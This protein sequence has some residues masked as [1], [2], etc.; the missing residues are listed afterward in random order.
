[1]RT[2]LLLGGMLTVGLLVYLAFVF[3]REDSSLSPEQTEFAVAD[4]SEVARIVLSQYRGEAMTQ[5]VR[6]HRG[7]EGW[8]VNEQSPALR[9][10]VQHL[11]RVM[12]RL[13]VRE[14]LNEAGERTANRFFEATRT[15]VEIMDADG[16]YLKHYFI[17]S[18]T[19]DARGT[20]MRM[21]DTETPY[22]VEMPGLQGY[23]KASFTLDPML[24]R[25]NRLFLADTS[26]LQQLR[27]E[28]TGQPAQS[29]TLQR[30]EQGRWRLAKAKARPHRLTALLSRF[31]GMVYAESF[32]NAD[33][34]GRQQQ[35]AEHAPDLRLRATYRDGRQRAVVLY[36]RS[37]NPNNLFAWVEGVE[38]L[39]TVQ[40]FVIDPFLPGRSYL[41]GESDV[42]RTPLDA[43]A[44]A[45]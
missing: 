5:Q 28:F 7:S 29:W 17:G 31:Q 38:E 13:A 16:Q 36:D 23:V 2:T 37:D 20:L 21:A 1:M 22:V 25:A 43:K 6:L 24:W 9:P 32:A 3:G 19:P 44:T 27:V 18:E 45:P 41:T 10:K 8:Q 11:L 39:L 12:S 4:T 42:R 14:V 30:D 15:E 26:R 33:Y 35:L 40:H 34:P